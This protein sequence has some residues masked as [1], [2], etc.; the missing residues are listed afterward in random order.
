M[1]TCNHKK[2]LT[3]NKTIIL[4]FAGY[5]ALQSPDKYHL[6]IYLGLY[7]FV[8]SKKIKFPQDTYLLQHC[9]F[10]CLG[11]LAIDFFRNPPGCVF[12]LFPGKVAKEKCPDFFHVSW[13]L[14]RQNGDFSI[15]IGLICTN[16]PLFEFLIPKC[17]C[18]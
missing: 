2:N 13:R 12:H 15:H 9:G 8:F 5:F 17:A 11:D 6:I 7:I 10:H 18:P 14:L 3:E 16:S 4:K 1:I